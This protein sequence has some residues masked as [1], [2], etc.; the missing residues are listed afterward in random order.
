MG[1]GKLFALLYEKG[2]V[3]EH[4]YH[5]DVARLRVRAP[6]GLAGVIES[7]GGRTQSVASLD[8]Q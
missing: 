7:M 2:Q 3:L 6:Q 4:T 5:D 8:A 1:N